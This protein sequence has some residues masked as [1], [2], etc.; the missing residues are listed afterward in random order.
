MQMR[1]L[2]DMAKMRFEMDRLEREQKLETM[3]VGLE[4]QKDEKRKEIEHD[5]WMADQ[6][7][8]L[9]ALRMRKVLAKEQPSLTTS[10]LDGSE[11][12][13]Y[14]PEAGFVIFWDYVLDIP[15]TT[16][17]IQVGFPFDIPIILVYSL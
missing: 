4:R 9:M 6:K 17:S 12:R 1:H 16:G 3:R 13:D 10:A 15:P 8:Q 11:K 14:N 7:R 5:K 2:E